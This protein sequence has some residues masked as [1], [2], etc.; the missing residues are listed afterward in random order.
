MMKGHQNIVILLAF[1]GLAALMACDKKQAE[2]P[3]ERVTVITTATVRQKDLPVI[4]SAIGSA[5]VLGAAEALNPNEMRRGSF[6]IRLPFPEWVA[7]QLRIGQ[8]V[9]LSSFDRSDK[10]ATAYVKQIRPALDSTT[11]TMEVIA[12]LPG[13]REWYSKGSVRGEVVLGV[14]KG[15][16]VVPE[17]AV[18][19][20]PAGSVVYVVNGDMANERAVTTG[21]LREGEIE[22]LSGL[23]P[24][25]T[26]TVDGA[27]QLSDGA[28]VRLRDAAPAATGGEGP[29]KP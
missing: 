5:T 20:R 3:P 4:E 7:R 15:A 29:V 26:V 27:A 24:G 25:E 6:T 13:G 14:H 1:A 17:H 16:L 21:M 23:K 9:R 10:T 2:K 18:V 28:K 12:E 11:Q 22:I 19:L 8:S